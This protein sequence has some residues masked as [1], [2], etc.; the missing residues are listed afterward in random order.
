MGSRIF[1]LKAEATDPARWS[2]SSSL[3]PGEKTAP[4]SWD[5]VRRLQ[6][7]VHDAA[8]VRRFERVGDLARDPQGIAYGH[9]PA[10][11]P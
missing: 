11:G 1:R 6:I 8:V 9:A 2:W 5:D 4:V 10:P 3:P 7:A